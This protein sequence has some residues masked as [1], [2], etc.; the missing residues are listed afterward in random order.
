MNGG[1]LQEDSARGAS[2]NASVINPA[3][4]IARLITSG[5]PLLG[6]AQSPGQRRTLGVQELAAV[7]QRQLIDTFDQIARGIFRRNTVPAGHL[8]RDHAARKYADGNAER[9]LCERWT[10]C[11]Q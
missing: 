5:C 4:N 8:G 2:K 6:P 3:M 11:G 7:V 10:L 1:K 9:F